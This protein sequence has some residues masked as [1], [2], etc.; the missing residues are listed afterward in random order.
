MTSVGTPNLCSV[1]TENRKGKEK[2]RLK[3]IHSNVHLLTLVKFFMKRIKLK[4]LA[5]EFYD[6]VSELFIQHISIRQPHCYFFE[7]CASISTTYLHF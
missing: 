5:S 2:K 1:M 7:H 4:R 6:N 3:T